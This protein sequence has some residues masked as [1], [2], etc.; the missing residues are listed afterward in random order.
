MHK[1]AK[2]EKPI[3]RVVGAV[4]VDNDSNKVLV[5]R[6][7]LIVSHPSKWEFVGGKVEPGE[8]PEE[9]LRRE[10]FE[11]TEADIEVGR[12][13]G[14]IF[15]DYRNKGSASHEILF[16]ECFL[17][18]G[19]PKIKPEV[20]QDIRWV[21]REDLLKLDFIEADRDFVRKL[22]GVKNE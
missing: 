7:S 1:E 2:K 17:Q 18:N 4:V 10:F 14:D 19:K 5:A 22:S 3:S 8:T 13:L 16:Y 21:S 11:E 6:R 15:Y 9:A 20:Y 12:F